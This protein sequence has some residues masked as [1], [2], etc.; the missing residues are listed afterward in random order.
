MNFKDI[1]KEVLIKILSSK[2]LLKEQWLVIPYVSKTWNSLA[3]TLVQTHIIRDNEHRNVFE[4]V[5]KNN[6]DFVL[7]RSKQYY[8]E[9]IGYTKF[10]LEKFTTNNLNFYLIWNGQIKGN[11]PLCSNS[12][13]FLK[14]VTR[15]NTICVTFQVD[16]IK[17][18]LHDSGNAYKL[19]KNNNYN[20]LP[21]NTFA[22]ISVQTILAE[23][24]TYFHHDTYLVP[25][26]ILSYI[27]TCK[28]L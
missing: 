1:P 28:N 6:H 22:N 24:I 8:I 15:K 16:N 20:F 26:I 19:E 2:I 23:S 25:E 11:I 21:I 18:D 17:Y 9:I 7:W 5:V 13:E 14:N 10:I 27:N 4:I 12:Q 3:K